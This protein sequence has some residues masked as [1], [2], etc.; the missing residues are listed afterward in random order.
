MLPGRRGPLSLPSEISGRLCFTVSFFVLLTPFF[1]CVTWVLTERLVCAELQ[2]GSL[3]TAEYVDAGTPGAEILDLA[4]RMW[5]APRTLAEHCR[6]VAIDAGAR[7]AATV[8]S[9]FLPLDLGIIKDGV[10]PNTTD[11]QWQALLDSSRAPVTELLADVCVNPGGQP[12][13]ADLQRPGLA[14]NV[15]EGVEDEDEDEDDLD[16]DAVLRESS[17]SPSPPVKE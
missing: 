17:A 4:S 15:D 2:S 8:K 12:L 1:V 9:W 10:H 11:D 7:V 14:A 13:A 16:V 5:A 3:R 6:E